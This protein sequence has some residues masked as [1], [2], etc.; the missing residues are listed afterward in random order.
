MMMNVGKLAPRDNIYGFDARSHGIV[1]SFHS[2]PRR[3]V[4]LAADL[5]EFGQFNVPNS[6]YPC[7][8]GKGIRLD[9]RLSGKVP[10]L[11]P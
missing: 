1:H 10:P 4:D 2:D 6:G 5:S 9:L 7:L 11:W 3:V 8:G